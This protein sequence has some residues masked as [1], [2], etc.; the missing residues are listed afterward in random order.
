MQIVQIG[1]IALY[2]SDVLNGFENIVHGFTTRKGGVSKG[3]Y[4]SLS[5]SP[6]RGDDISCVRENERILCSELG[7]QLDRLS[8]TRQEHTDNI[9]IIDA[10]NIGVGVSSDWGKG[11]DACI[12]LEK[13]VPILCYSADCVPILM[14]ARDIE[15]IAAVHSGW[16]GSALS[17]GKKTVEKLIKMGAEPQNIFVAIGPSIGKCCYEVSEDVA[18]QFSPEFYTAKENG[19]YMLDLGMVNYS[20]IRECLVPVE[21]ISLSEIC[22]SC[23]NDLFFSH[24]RQNGKSGTLGG[25]ICMK[26]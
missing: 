7:L 26:E 21:N 16:K 1:K 24:R 23:N 9:E 17:I 19:K 6:R 4:E 18:Q 13:N 20:L 3:E 22:T 5:M 2:Q 10:E 14:Y 11:V 15:A 8:S 25:I 12:T